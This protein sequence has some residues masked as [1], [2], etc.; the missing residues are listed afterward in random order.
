MRT[1]AVTDGFLSLSFDSPGLSNGQLCQAMRSAL[2][3]AGLVQW[4][5]IDADIFTYRGR[6][7]VLARPAPPLLRRVSAGTP[8]IKRR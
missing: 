6:T 5:H 7:L 4:R 2:E 8:R 1:E 3:R